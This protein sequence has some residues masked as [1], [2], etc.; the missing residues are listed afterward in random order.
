M[1]AATSAAADPRSRAR[2]VLKSESVF[3]KCPD[4]VIDEIMRHAKHSKVS[5]G[6]PVCRQHDPGDSMMVVLS[7]SF[8]VTTVTAEA[9]E[10]VLNF[11][12]SGAMVGEI[13]CFD[14]GERTANVVALE[15]C[16][17]VTVAGRSARSRLP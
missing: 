8:K 14:G 7:G 3:S 2:S 17:I 4:A 12:K 5:K 9:K 6:E 11:L 16:E 10:V 1:S 15:P 13:A